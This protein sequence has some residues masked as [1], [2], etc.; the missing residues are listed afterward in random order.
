M[1]T[2]NWEPLFEEN[3]EVRHTDLRV[4]APLR[5]HFESLRYILTCHQVLFSHLSS[6]SKRFNFIPRNLALGFLIHYTC[7]PYPMVLSWRQFRPSSSGAF[8]YIHEHFW[9]LHGRARSQDAPGLCWVEARHAAKHL[10]ITQES[11]TFKNYLA[12]NVKS[13]AVE[14]SFF[15]IRLFSLRLRSI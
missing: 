9:L 5:I 3:S 11:S 10:T 2:P 4:Y 12:Q 6:F 1:G 13:T 8:C 14:R 7:V 15:F